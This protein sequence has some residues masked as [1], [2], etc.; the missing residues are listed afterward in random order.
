VVAVTAA[1]S[2]VFGALYVAIPAFAS[3]HGRAGAA[4]VLLALLNV[5]GLAGGILIA[6]RSSAR[7]AVERY[8]LLSLLLAAS[9]APLALARSIGQMGL[10]LVVAGA[11]VAPTATASY[12]LVDLV[13]S[14]GSRTEAFT[15]MSTAVAAGTAI[16]SAAGGTLAEYVGVG[17]ALGFAGGAAAAGAGAAYLVRG[18]LRRQA[19]V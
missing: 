3:A 4:G 13:A 7:G 9:V 5:G 15:W 8:L 11:F 19:Q 16:G 18:L 10:L 1:Q 17:A 12:V 14:V 2:V 6:S